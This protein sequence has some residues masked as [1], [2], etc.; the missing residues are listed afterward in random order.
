MGSVGID[1]RTSFLKHDLAKPMESDA[2]YDLAV[3]NLVFHNMGKKRFK[4]YGTVFDALRPRRFFV[5][6]DLFPYGK[7]DMDYFCNLSL[8]A[9]SKVCGTQWY[10]CKILIP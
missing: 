6:G 10:Q 3:S 8:V 1:S 9:T 2:L 4:A 5:I 7:S